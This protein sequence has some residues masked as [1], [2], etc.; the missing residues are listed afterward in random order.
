MNYLEAKKLKE[1][2]SHIIGLKYN[3]SIIDELIIHPT[4][5]KEFEKFIKEYLD[6][7]DAQKAIL[8]FKEKDVIVS[9]VFDKENTWERNIFL[10][11]PLINL[12]N[13]NLNI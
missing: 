7:F 2:N 9:A 12:E 1:K 3:G 4:E 8:G 6:S 13:L 10:Q 11:T 5:P